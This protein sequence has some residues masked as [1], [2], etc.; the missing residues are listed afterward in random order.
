MSTRSLTRSKSPGTRPSI[1]R[2]LRLERKLEELF[3][4][5]GVDRLGHVV[6][7]AGVPREAPMPILS[8]A[9]ERY[10]D[11]VPEPDL[12][13]EAPSDLKTIHLRHADV[14][15]DNLGTVGGGDLERRPSV[16]RRR[17]I[18]TEVAHEL[19]ER[20]GGVAIVIN[21]QDPARRT[22]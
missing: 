22:H 1:A 3:E 13:T 4:L 20:L 11:R 2:D 7:K 16:V 5:E 19:R 17:D 15:Q 21:D 6:V 8:V 14:E 10:E 12:F 18:V 9:G